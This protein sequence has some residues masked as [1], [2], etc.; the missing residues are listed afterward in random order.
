MGPPDVLSNLLAS[1]SAESGAI[2]F[3]LAL[4]LCLFN[5]DFLLVPFFSLN[6]AIFT[7]TLLPTVALNIESN[8]P[9]SLPDF[10]ATTNSHG[11]P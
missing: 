11:Y 9:M 6:V 4:L 1:I 8:P 2:S 10:T 7:N 3:S 5:G